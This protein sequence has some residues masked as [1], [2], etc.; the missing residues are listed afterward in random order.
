[1]LVHSRF[2]HPMFSC[3]IEVLIVQDLLGESLQALCQLCHP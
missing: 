1:M 2:G 3:L